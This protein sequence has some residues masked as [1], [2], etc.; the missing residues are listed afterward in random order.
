V[1]TSRLTKDTEYAV[2]LAKDAGPAVGRATMWKE[3]FKSRGYVTVNYWHAWLHWANELGVAYE[4]A[5]TRIANVVI[6]SASGRRAALRFEREVWMRAEDY[7]ALT[8]FVACV[9]G[10]RRATAA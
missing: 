2:I 6:A 5:P 1:S 4:V 8:A 3:Q 9:L 7:A 10:G